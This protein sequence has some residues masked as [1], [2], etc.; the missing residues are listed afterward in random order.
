[1]VIMVVTLMMIK[2]YCNS[3]KSN[4]GQVISVQ[5]K[6]VTVTQRVIMVF[7]DISLK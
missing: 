5:L 1:M 2:L 7:C 6:F 4:S 3:V